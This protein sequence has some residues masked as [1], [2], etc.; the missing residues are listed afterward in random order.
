MKLVFC[1]LAICLSIL[2]SVLTLK[3]AVRAE[4]KRTR[5]AIPKALAEPLDESKDP[6]SVVRKL[7]ALQA[8][9]SALNKRL[10]LLEDAGQRNGRQTAGAA[11][12]PDP[13]LAE[14]RALAASVQALSGGVERLGGVPDQLN[15]LTTYLDQS[16][17]HL[18]ARVTEAAAPEDLLVAIDWLVKKVDDIDSYFTPLY[19]FLG[20]VYDP[21]NQDLLEAYPSVDVRI[22]DLS[23]RLDALQ[24]EVADFRRLMVSPRI[25]EPTRTPR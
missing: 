8:Q 6:D 1:T 4:G 10:A 5:T 21:A 11:P 18:E 20:V 15:G 13:L 19:T 2:A 16:F 14:V 25:V 17:A 9:L 7:D 12:A 22:N 23:A 24:K 3:E